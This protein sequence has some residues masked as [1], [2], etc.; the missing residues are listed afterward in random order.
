[1]V[2]EPFILHTFAFEPPDSSCDVTRPFLYLVTVSEL[3]RSILHA[4]I[5]MGTE[6]R[7]NFS[8]TVTVGVCQVSVGEEI[9]KPQKNK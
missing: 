6:A 5:A 4:G 8:V 1:M 9:S 3:C 2:L 7:V